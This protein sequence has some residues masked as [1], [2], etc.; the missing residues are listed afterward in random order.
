MATMVL[1]A[2]GSGQRVGAGVNKALL[3]VGGRPLLAWSLRTFDASPS[4][5][6]VVVVARAEDVSTIREIIAGSST[7]VVAVTAG[8]PTRHQSEQRG[9]TTVAELAPQASHVVGFH[10]AARPLVSVDLVE[11]VLDAARE[12]G[13]WPALPIQVVR[14]S[15]GRVDG[16]PFVALRAQT[17]QAFRYDVLVDAFARAAVDGFEGTDTAATVQR[18]GVALEAVEGDPANL[19]V[20]IAADLAEVERRLI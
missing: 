11:R 7:K 3:E 12:G 10:D 6:R 13:A 15:D 4:V 18:C 14:A 19:K 2:A 9:L 8:G 1:L 5:E 20:T 17:P 16:E